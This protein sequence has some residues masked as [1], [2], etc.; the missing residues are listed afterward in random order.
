MGARTGQA[1]TARSSIE[2]RRTV[3]E[4]LR[5]R[6]AAPHDGEVAP[7]P[8][9]LEL[10][11]I[12]ERHDNTKAWVEVT[13]GFNEVTRTG[14]SPSVSVKS[15]RHGIRRTVLG[16]LRAIELFFEWRFTCELVEVE[17]VLVLGA[18]LI[19]ARVA[20]RIDD[21]R[22][23][24]FGTARVEGDLQEAAAKA[25]LDATNRYIDAVLR[26]PD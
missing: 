11:R 24:L 4:K 2:A 13:L 19:A 26:L 6:G 23:E 10:E 7:K 16:T 14:R 22:V 20:I 1:G 18:P 21:E 15:G 17:H 5:Y 25:T 8:V 3:T 9:W 12:D